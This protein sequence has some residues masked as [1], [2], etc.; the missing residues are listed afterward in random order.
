MKKQQ[1]RSDVS[2]VKERERGKQERAEIVEEKVPEREET[3]EERKKRACG[4]VNIRRNKTDL[5]S[6]N[7]CEDHNNGIF[8]LKCNLQPGP[9][10]TH[11][12]FQLNNGQKKLCVKL[13]N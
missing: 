4:R 10:P 11:Y 2:N 12:I 13:R 6:E 8:F 1:S 7:V 5:V 3:K 9:R